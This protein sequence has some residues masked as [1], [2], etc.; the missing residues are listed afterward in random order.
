M[1]FERCRSDLQCVMALLREMVHLRWPCT[2]MERLRRRKN[3]GILPGVKEVWYGEL[4]EAGDQGIFYE[5]P[6]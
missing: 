5:A 3:C 2:G 1:L 4:Y 6:E